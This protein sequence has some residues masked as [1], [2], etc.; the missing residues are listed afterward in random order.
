MAKARKISR[1]ETVDRVL[2]G[3]ETLRRPVAKQNVADTLKHTLKV[4]NR[5]MKKKVR[6]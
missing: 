2:F 5:A 4:L 1:E 3:R 6:K